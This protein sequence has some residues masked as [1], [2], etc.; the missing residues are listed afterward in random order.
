V[1]LDQRPRSIEDNDADGI[2]VHHSSQAIRSGGY[3]V[4]GFFAGVDI[5]E[6]DYDSI[7]AILAG[8]VR[9]QAGEVPA[10]GFI[11]QL[12]F[13]GNEAAQYRF[14]VASQFGIAEPIA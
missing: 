4:L 5:D 10:A 2:D 7:D 9:K 1:A 13:N 11:P 8:A 12:A 6:V 3:G 14:G